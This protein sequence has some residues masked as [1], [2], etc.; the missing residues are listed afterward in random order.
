MEI[1]LVAIYINFGKHNM[2]LTEFG[3]HIVH[4]DKIQ[5]LVDN[6]PAAV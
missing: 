2:Q 1:H 4:R 6:F 5:L 3:L